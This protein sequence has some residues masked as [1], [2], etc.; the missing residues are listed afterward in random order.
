MTQKPYFFRFQKRKYQRI[1]TKYLQL[2]YLASQIQIPQPHTYK[3]LTLDLAYNLTLTE[4]F[5]TI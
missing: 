1:L 3:L 4:L 5:L 2:G